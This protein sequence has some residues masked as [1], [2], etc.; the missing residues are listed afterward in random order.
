MIYKVYV[1]KNGTA[2]SVGEV[3]VENI[4]EAQAEV[5]MVAKTCNVWDIQDADDFLLCSMGEEVIAYGLIRAGKFKVDFPILGYG[6]ERYWD[7]E[8]VEYSSAALAAGYDTLYIAETHSGLIKSL[9]EWTKCGWKVVD[10]V[11]LDDPYEWNSGKKVPM[12]K[13]AKV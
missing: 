6:H 12:I 13:F 3:T 10:I 7:N 9:V 5:L 8:I 4:N 2:V 1:K 11:E